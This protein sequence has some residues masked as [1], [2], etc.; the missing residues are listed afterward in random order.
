[1]LQDLQKEIQTLLTRVEEARELLDLDHKRDRVRELEAEMNDQGFWDDQNEA[2]AVSSNHAALIEEI[3]DWDAVHQEVIDA[4]DMVGLMLEEPAAEQAS[5]EKEVSKKLEE[6]L[7][8]FEKMETQLLFQGPYDANDAIVSIHAGAGGVDAQD[9]S[10]MLL[11]MLSRFVEGKGWSVELVDQSKG[12]EAGIKSAMLFIHGRYAYGHLQGEH[13]IHRLVRLSPFNSDSLRQTS[14]ASIEV[15]PDLGDMEE[16]EIKEEDLRIDTFR[17]SGAGGQHVNVTD[18]AVRIVHEPTGIT[19][20]VQ[21]ERS[22]QQN[23]A[24]AMAILRS[25]IGLQIEEERR[26][27]EAKAKGEYKS[28]EWGN[29]IRSYVLHPYK[30]V[31]DH[32]TNVEDSDPNRVL[33]G[34][35]DEFIEAYLRWQAG[36]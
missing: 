27:E 7:G 33:G 11:R 8:R 31:K 18:S 2:K 25:K 19:V 6:L 17:A 26:A 24:K 32:R 1:M 28:A 4:R 15:V 13:G 9:W 22:Q 23:K 10:E 36:K 34:D 21:N 16:V 3:G 35:L 30:M 29:Q 12:G 20:S 14:F 5:V